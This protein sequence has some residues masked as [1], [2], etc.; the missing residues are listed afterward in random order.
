MFDFHFGKVK[1]KFRGCINDFEVHGST[2]VEL[3]MFPV[4]LQGPISYD[5]SNKESYENIIFLD[6]MITM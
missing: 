4:L 1:T 2:K 5:L 6:Q 3:I